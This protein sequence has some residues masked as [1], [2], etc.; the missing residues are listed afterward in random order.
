LAIV[1]TA[2]GVAV[3]PTAL[4]AALYL[5]LAWMVGGA[6]LPTVIA[7]AIPPGGHSRA[8]LFDSLAYSSTAF[9]GPIVAG[10]LIEAISPVAALAAGALCSLVYA[11]LLW[12]VQS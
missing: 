6:G 10:I 4:L 9:I 1:A 11:G 2:S 12:S 7:G 8:N 3:V 5:G